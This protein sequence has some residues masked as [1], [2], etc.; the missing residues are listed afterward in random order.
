[1]IKKVVYYGTLLKLAKEL[2]DSEISGDGYNEA[3]RRHDDY[4]LLCLDADYMRI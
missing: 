2:A 1:M 3:K 4:M